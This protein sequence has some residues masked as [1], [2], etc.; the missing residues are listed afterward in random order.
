MLRQRRRETTPIHH[1]SMMGHAHNHAPR[2]PSAG[3]ATRI[4]YS[5]LICGTGGREG[6]GPCYGQRSLEATPTATRL[7][8][9]TPMCETTPPASERERR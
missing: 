4:P 8:E 6:R 3:S 5:R 9:A 7:H 2:Y 1:A